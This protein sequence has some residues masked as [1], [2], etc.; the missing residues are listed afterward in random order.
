[1]P[2]EKPKSLINNKNLLEIQ[3]SLLILSEF[4][5]NAGAIWLIMPTGTWMPAYY[6]ENSYKISE[7]F[8][9]TDTATLYNAGLS[10][11]IAGNRR[12]QL[13]FINSCWI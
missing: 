12:E 13:K 10:A 7:G 4:F 2:L 6:F 1:M 3:Q 11:E 5:F 9:S 8:G